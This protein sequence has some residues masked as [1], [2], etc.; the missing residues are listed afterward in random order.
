MKQLS[1]FNLTLSFFAL[2]LFWL[3]MS[4]MFEAPQL[5]QGVVSVGL[6]LAINYRLKQ[7]K[8]FEDEMDDLKSLRFHYAIFYVFWLVWEIVKSGLYV[9]SVILS[10][11]MP[12]ETY[13]LKF[14][15]DLPSAH[16]RMILGNSITLTPGTLTIDIEDDLFTVHALTPK[17]FEGIID[18][19]MPDKVLRLFSTEDRNVI[20][21]IQVLNQPEENQIR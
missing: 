4:G 13:I 7:Y 6:V 12:I 2:M 10:K 3:V 20:H 9:A 18:G 5:I 15:V 14:R 19:T 8:F 16:A 21:D 17:S 11:K 1:L